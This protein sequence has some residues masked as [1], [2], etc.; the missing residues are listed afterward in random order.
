MKELEV[1]AQVRGGGRGVG[2]ASLREGRPH[3]VIGGLG[4]GGAGSARV[5]CLSAARRPAS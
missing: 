2:A 1:S 3:A 5:R 4:G